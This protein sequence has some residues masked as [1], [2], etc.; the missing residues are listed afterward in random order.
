M[1]T[2]YVIIKRYEK[3][4]AAQTINVGFHEEEISEVCKHLIN[5][6]VIFIREFFTKSCLECFTLADIVSEQVIEIGSAIYTYVIC[7]GLV[8]IL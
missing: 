6:F 2:W 4:P 7:H 8:Y 1:R 3:G 5:L